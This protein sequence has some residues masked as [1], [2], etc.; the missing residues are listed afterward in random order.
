VLVG[1]TDKRVVFRVG[2]DAG[3]PMRANLAKRD[4]GQGDSHVKGEFPRGYQRLIT[5]LP[6]LFMGVR[7]LG[8]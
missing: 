1:E 8:E 6:V 7:R 3:S 4:A 5:G 2:S